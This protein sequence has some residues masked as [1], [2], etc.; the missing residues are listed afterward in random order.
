MVRSRR[1]P[2]CSRVSGRSRRRVLGGRRISGA[3]MMG[4]CGVFAGRR[5]RRWLGTCSGMGMYS[6]RVYL[7]GCGHCRV[8]R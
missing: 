6:G 2:R 5:R 3:M 8:G 1:G 4:R 7:S